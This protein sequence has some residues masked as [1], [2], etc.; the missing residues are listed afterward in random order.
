MRMAIILI[1]A[2][3]GDIS[4]LSENVVVNTF[5]FTGTGTDAQADSLFDLIE[6][7]YNDPIGVNNPVRSYL[8]DNMSRAIGACTLRAYNLA[9]PT[10][11]I[12]FHERSWT[13]GAGL[14]TD[15]LPSEVACCI[16]YAGAKVSGSPQARRRGRIYVGRLNVSANANQL[17]V[18]R[19]NGVFTNILL[20][21]AQ[22]L[23][24]QSI[25]LGAPWSVYSRVNNSNTPIVEVSVDDAWDTQRRR[26]ER[27]TLK[28]TL[29][30]S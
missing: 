9:D 23:G 25:D 8:S 29:P 1:Q 18:S 21:A 3:I 11:R 4:A 26:G 22:R 5:H 30:V 17:E 24:D 15:P 16:S 14:G 19:P 2:T 27:P 13:L 7:F 10:P 12:P 20:L 6:D 28:S